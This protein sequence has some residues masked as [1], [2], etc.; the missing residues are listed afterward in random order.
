MDFYL[1]YCF[2]L[3]ACCASTISL[4]VELGHLCIFMGLTQVFYYL[5]PLL[6]KQIDQ[7][8]G[9]AIDVG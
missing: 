5:E 3:S 2:F 4:K 6:V 7:L 1:F 8:S 9:K